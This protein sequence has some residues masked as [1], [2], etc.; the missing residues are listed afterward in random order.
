MVCKGHFIIFLPVKFLK[1]ISLMFLTVTFL[2]A[3]ANI[4]GLEGYPDD[5]RII[6][7]WSTTVEAEVLGFEVQRSTGN[8]NFIDIGFLEAKGGNS[9]YTFIDD[10]IIAKVAG[11][12]YDYR[13]KIRNMDG[14]YE[15]SE[16][17]TVESITQNLE[18]TWG[19][20]KA[21]FK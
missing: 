17:I 16:V 7:Q 4:V 3:S 2:A 12:E 13:L 5:A 19:S 1:A 6:I 8:Q 10:S 11:R 14:S 21:L 18:H 9:S 20:L 15:Y